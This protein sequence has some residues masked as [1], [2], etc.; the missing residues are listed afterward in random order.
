MELK[1]ITVWHDMKFF[2]GE[3]TG[4]FAHCYDNDII[5]PHMQCEYTKSKTEISKSNAVII[6]GRELGNHWRRIPRGSEQL[7]VFWESEAPPNFYGDVGRYNDVFNLTATFTQ[8]SD[9]PIDTIL[10]SLK[11][12]R[13]KKKWKSLEMRNFTAKKRS[14]VIV[15]WFVSNCNAQ[16]ERYDYVQKLQNH[17]KVDIYGKCGNHTCGVSYHNWRICHKLLLHGNNSYKFYLSFENSLCD[18]YVTEKLWRI[19]N[20]DVVPVVMGLVNYSKIFPPDSY[21]DVRDFKS[22]TDL[23]EYLLHL[24]RNHNLYNQYLRNKGSLVCL[25]MVQPV[26]WECKLCQY[27]HKKAGHKSIVHN[28]NAFWGIESRCVS[29]KIYHKN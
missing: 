22:P 19:L 15:A 8:D 17:I 29:P 4:S 28:L 10:S 16:S 6:R 23:A 7:W 26:L 21:I 12:E 25:P 1:L 9:I 13:D 3:I 11:C 14:D 18:E 20:I 5:D 24:N 27:L 2:H